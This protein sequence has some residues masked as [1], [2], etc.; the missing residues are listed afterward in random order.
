M[1]FPH[2]IEAPRERKERSIRPRGV[3]WAV[4]EAQGNSRK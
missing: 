1:F 4:A 3:T 2:K